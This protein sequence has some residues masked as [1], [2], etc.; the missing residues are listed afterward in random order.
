[1]KFNEDKCHLLIAG[2]KYEN[3]WVKVGKEKF[4]KFSVKN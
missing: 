1:M 3:V 4:E 2:H